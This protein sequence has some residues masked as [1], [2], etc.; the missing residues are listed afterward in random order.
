MPS[1]S[2]QSQA[3][4]IGGSMAGLLAAR[5][6]ADHFDRVTLIER[7]TLPREP[8]SRAGAPQARHIHVMLFRGQAILDELFPRLRGE[9]AVAEAPSID[10]TADARIHGIAGWMVR[11]PSELKGYLCTRDLL[12]HLVR[13][14]VASLPRV[15]FI[16]RCEVVGLVAE[17][18]RVV[19]VRLRRRSGGRSA[20]DGSGEAT[21]ATPGELR[22]D[23]VVDASGRE[24]RAPDWLEALGF[25]RPE[26][27]VV[28]SFLGYA[29]RLYEPPAAF[30]FDW[31][32]LLV[33][34]VAPA[35]RAG[36]IYPMEGG[37]WI[38]TLGGVARDFPPTDEEGFLDFAR[39]LPGGE[40]HRALQAA[41]PL[42]PI[43][44][45][46]RTANRLRHFE[47][48]ARW[49]EGFVALGDAVC[50]FNPVYGQG[51]TTAAI[52]AQALGDALRRRRGRGMARSFQRHLA[53]LIADPWLLATGEDFRYSTTEGSAPGALT[54]LMH[55]YTYRVL[56]RATDDPRLLLA[57]WEVV[58]MFRPPA[59]LLHPLVALKA[60][61]PSGRL[62]RAPRSAP[63]KHSPE[64]W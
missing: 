59:S 13:R 58:H 51:M 20:G 1:G 6:L 63:A 55:R 35:T 64:R 36:G 40:L 48:L 10:W 33:R 7:D 38:V 14:E 47:R 53:R 37:G 11:F 22:C 31:K 41:R 50:A 24:S 46:R 4:V 57:F 28:N 29:S 25:G 30:Q 23:L 34:S 56:L 12:E 17:G 19:G 8:A 45:Y 54:R 9:L 18:D 43:Y 26:D 42:S 62:G 49:P 27:T 16:E 21:D 32:L 52:A 61:A 44:G 5:V 15:R 3:V 39:S 2:S 60:L